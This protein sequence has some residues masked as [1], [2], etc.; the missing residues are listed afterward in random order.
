MNAKCCLLYIFIQYSGDIFISPLYQHRKFYHIS[1]TEDNKTFDVDNPFTRCCSLIIPR[2]LWKRPLLFVIVLLLVNELF[3]NNG[4]R[5]A[6]HAPLDTRHYMNMVV[7]SSAAAKNP[8]Y[9]VCIKFHNCW[10]LMF[11][12]LRLYK[13]VKP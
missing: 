6:S 3:F 8:C 12:N 13:T 5:R 2:L 1:M 10:Q 11:V 4:F 7:V 9:I